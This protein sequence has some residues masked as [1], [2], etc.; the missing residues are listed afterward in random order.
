MIDIIAAIIIC[1]IF[2]VMAGYIAHL[3]IKLQITEVKLT[4]WI[5]KTLN[6]INKGK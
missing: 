4:W 2:V 5:Q 6:I 1:V 3:K